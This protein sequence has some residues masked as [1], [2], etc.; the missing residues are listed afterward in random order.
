M[1]RKKKAV[2]VKEFEAPKAEEGA[3]EAP[4]PDNLESNTLPA[5]QERDLDLTGLD[6]EEVSTFRDERVQDYR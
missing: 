6:A 3:Y 5:K 4:N 2:P 1:A